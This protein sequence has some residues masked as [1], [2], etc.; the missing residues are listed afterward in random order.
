MY[1]ATE[2]EFLVVGTVFA[3]APPNVLLCH[4]QVHFA[5]ASITL[6][7]PANRPALTL[8]LSASVLGLGDDSLLGILCGS[9]WVPASLLN[10]IMYIVIILSPISYV[11]RDA[12][13]HCV[14]NFSFRPHK[15]LGDKCYNYR[16][17][18]AT[19]QLKPGA[20]ISQDCTV[21]SSMARV[22]MP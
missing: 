22:K 21:E 5:K 11:K 16:L 8:H 14:C 3:I 4:F 10:G 13:M 2:G 15:H 18:I 1:G 20:E 12:K 9:S 6:S 19:L 7:H 17:R